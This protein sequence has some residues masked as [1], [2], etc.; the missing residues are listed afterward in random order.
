MMSS[1]STRL[2]FITF[3]IISLTLAYLYGF[4][5]MDGSFWQIGSDPDDAMRYVQIQDWLN[6][7]SWHDTNQYRLGLPVGT[8]MHWSRLPDFPV[9][10]LTLIFDIF[11]ERERAFHLAIA[12][13]PP[14]T[15]AI[16]LLIFAR[17]AA[18][19]SN[20]KT[21]V[22]AHLFVLLLGAI[23]MCLN[24][25][26]SPGAID[27]HN[28]QFVLLA[29][30]VVSLLTYEKFSPALIGGAAAATAFA[31]GPEVYP[32]VAIIGIFVSLDW[33]S[34]GLPRRIRTQGF[35][36]GFA[37]SLV[38]IFMITTGS[39]DFMTIY[40]DQ[41]SI[42]NVF[43]GVIAGLTLALAATLSS[44]KYFVI[45]IAWL[46]FI[47][48]VALTIISTAAPQ[49][50]GN[51]LNDLPPEIHTFWLDHI[52]EAQPL[53]ESDNIFLSISL[54]LGTSVVAFLVISYKVWRHGLKSHSILL[55]LLLLLSAALTFYQVRFFPFS[56][57]LVILPLGLWVA[58][59]H[60]NGKNKKHNLE[61][62]GALA[63]SIPMILA[64][65]AILF[66][67]TEEEKTSTIE[68]M[69]T[70]VI[71]VY[72][73]LPKGTI[74]AGTSDGSTLIKN[75]EHHIIAANYHRNTAGIS[76]SISINSA[77][78]DSAKDQL[79]KNNIT[80]FGTC[81]NDVLGA[82]YKESFPNSLA[83]KLRND[84]TFDWLVPVTDNNKLINKN[85]KIYKIT[86]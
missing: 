60:A 1:V 29:L 62:I 61:Y 65:P 79:R 39:K 68:C 25:R 80:Y 16:L 37:G 82:L 47:G 48:L 74:L 76:L 9:V 56:Q 84:E 22:S 57:L 54:Y 2:H 55:A 71:D 20:E 45:R 73:A 7:Q 12:I 19:L 27:H 59:C 85:V 17:G 66:E 15:G 72:T 43:L 38:F 67:P 14:M 69:S 8:D 24:S 42:I 41:L 13:W 32:F 35:G 83:A 18:L 11:L 5:L 75:T 64:L 49:C 70:D 46:G 21:R 36:I 52:T 50:L 34:L 6:G 58:A 10:M 31:I 30:T 86:N 78:P 77:D 4:A 23:Y 3:A 53:I 28:I 26:F 44:E 33:A 63:L 51:P 40:C 81:D